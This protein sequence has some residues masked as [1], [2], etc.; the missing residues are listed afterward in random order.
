MYWRFG[1][2]SGDSAAA[3]LLYD[4]VGHFIRRGEG[5]WIAIARNPALVLSLLLHVHGQ[6]RAV[7]ADQICAFLK[8]PKGTR[9]KGHVDQLRKKIAQCGIDPKLVLEHANNQTGYRLASDVGATMLVEADAL[10]M[11]DDLLARSATSDPSIREGLTQLRMLLTACVIVALAYLGWAYLRTPDGA[12]IAQLE[13]AELGATLLPP[14]G[15]HGVVSLSHGT[16]VRRD[17]DGYLITLAS[18]AGATEPPT[19][20]FVLP[21]PR[22]LHERDVLTFDLTS[23]APARIAIRAEAEPPQAARVG[24]G[25]TFELGPGSPGSLHLPATE[26]DPAARVAMKR[27]CIAASADGTA[28]GESTLELRLRAVRVE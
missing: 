11:I 8:L 13:E 3:P 9:I 21:R 15:A 24:E 4:E 28:G 22:A 14:L 23:E 17:A 6:G 16:S 12:P 19:A 10:R 20:C 5:P 2:T 18:A 27:L 26:L 1:P 25:K 7:S